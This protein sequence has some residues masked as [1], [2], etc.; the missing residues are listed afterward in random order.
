[1]LSDFLDKYEKFVKPNF[2]KYIEPTKKYADMIIP[3]YGFSTSSELDLDSMQIPALD[4]IIK[5]VLDHQ[6]NY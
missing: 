1:M 6:N 4:L 2:E 5:K 3:N